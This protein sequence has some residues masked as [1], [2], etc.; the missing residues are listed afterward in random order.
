MACENCNYGNN[1]H[2][3]GEPWPNK[4]ECLYPYSVDE[5]VPN[6]PC[7]FIKGRFKKPR[8]TCRYFEVKKTMELL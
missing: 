2:E 8:D 4:V 3:T 7:D 6:E 1:Y 5:I